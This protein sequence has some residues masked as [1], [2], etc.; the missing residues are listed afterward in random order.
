MKIGEIRKELS[1]QGLVYSELLDLGYDDDKKFLVP[2]EDVMDLID[3][4]EREVCDISYMLED[5]EGL[6]E[7]DEIKTKVHELEYGVC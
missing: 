3:K 5:I 6:S 4:I 1:R 7:I 2:I